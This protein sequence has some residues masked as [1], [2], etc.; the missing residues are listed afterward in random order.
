MFCIKHSSA[1]KFVGVS[2]VTKFGPERVT[3]E[4]FITWLLTQVHLK[5]GT[6]Q[7]HLHGDVK[8]EWLALVTPPRVTKSA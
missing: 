3:D 4:N 1:L 7:R 2:T 8:R 6:P 5:S